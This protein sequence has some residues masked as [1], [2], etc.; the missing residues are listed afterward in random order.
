VA[1]IGGVVFGLVLLP[2]I[3]L[4]RFGPPANN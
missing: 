1:L 2:Y 4:L 3:F